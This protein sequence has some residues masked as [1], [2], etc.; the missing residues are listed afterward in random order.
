[1]LYIHDEWR[2]IMK[3]WWDCNTFF[4]KI[5]LSLYYFSKG[6]KLAVSLRERKSRRRRTQ[7]GGGLLYWPFL[8]LRCE[9]LTCLFT[10]LNLLNLSPPGPPPLLSTWWP[11]SKLLDCPNLLCLTN[12]PWLTVLFVGAYVYRISQR[13]RILPVGDSRDLLPAVN[14]RGLTSCLH[15]WNILFRDSYLKGLSKV[16]MQPA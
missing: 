10:S 4:T 8:Y 9:F 14:P 15:S 6:P 5:Y 13:L 1:M 3:E 12:W 11:L 7:T 16:N 2:T